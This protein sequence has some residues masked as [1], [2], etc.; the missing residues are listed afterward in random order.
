MQLLG[1]VW[2]IR[3]WVVGLAYVKSVKLYSHL[4]NEALGEEEERTRMACTEA[5]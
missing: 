2:G 5:Y 3:E 4:K 1:A